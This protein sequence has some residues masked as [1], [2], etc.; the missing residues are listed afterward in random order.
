MIPYLVSGRMKHAPIAVLLLTFFVACLPLRAQD[1]RFVVFQDGK[2]GYINEKGVVVIPAS[3][4]ETHV[5]LFSEGMASFA[6][7]D[8]NSSASFPFIDSN[9]VP[10]LSRP[11]KWGFIDVSGHVV[12]RPDFDDVGS[13]SEGLAAVGVDTDKDRHGCFNCDKGRLWGFV[14]KQGKLV[15]MPQYRLVGR[16]SEGLAPVQ[17][18]NQ[19]W[20]YINSRGDVVIPFAFDF[21]DEF[22]DGLAMVRV[23]E[24][25]GYI[26]PQG[27]FVIQPAFSVAGRF[28]GGL[29][30]VRKG[31]KTGPLVLGSQGG[32]WSFIGKDGTTKIK[33]PTNVETARGFSEGL[34]A[35]ENQ[36]GHC[37][38]VNASGAFV[39]RAQYVGCEDFS[40]GLADVAIGSATG[41]QWLY[42]KKTGQVA[43][44]VPYWEVHPF[45]DGLA[46]VEEGQ[47]GPQQK[48]GYIDK[49]GKEVWKPRPAL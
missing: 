40:E 20:G 1:N 49:S 23:G 48:F 18:D 5:I 21:G 33:L 12:I 36:D 22:S 15:A 30:A 24:A 42:I 13:F 29:A 10:H 43:L 47:E 46:L 6:M 4:D 9:G 41:E 34:A 7:E 3:L 25:S 26:D 27:A 44:K 14:D 38:Y 17:D 37:G 32:A 8:P 39:V 35:V 45:K 19:K 28:S 31:G 11:E 16:F 2:H